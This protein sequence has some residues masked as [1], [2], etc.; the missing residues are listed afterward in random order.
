M[1][2]LQDFGKEY[3]AF[4][5]LNTDVVAIST[6]DVEASRSLKA[7]KDGIAFPMPILPDPKL[8]F[9]KAYRSYDDFE[10]TPLHGAFLI[11]AQG[12]RP[13]PADLGRSVP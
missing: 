11:D 6:D 13:V 1:Q 9:F 8:A 7:N 3:G 10:N 4:Q 12:L 5:K 2:Q